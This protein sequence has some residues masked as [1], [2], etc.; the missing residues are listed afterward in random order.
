MQVPVQANRLEQIKALFGGQAVHLFQ[1][2]DL[3]VLIGLLGWGYAHITLLRVRR[4]NW[5]NRVDQG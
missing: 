1:G 3:A 4:A 5:S 2:V